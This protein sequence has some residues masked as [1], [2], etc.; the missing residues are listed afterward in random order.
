MMVVAA[1]LVGLR[2]RRRRK[3]RHIAKDNAAHYYSTPEPDYDTVDGE[4]RKL[5]V[6]LLLVDYYEN[7]GQGGG[8]GEGRKKES[9]AIDYY[10]D[11]ESDGGG[12]V[13]ANPGAAYKELQQSGLQE[14][15]YTHIYSTCEGEG[16]L[17]TRE[18]PAGEASKTDKQLAYGRPGGEPHY[19]ALNMDTVIKSEYDKPHKK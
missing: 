19:T 4:G 14:A 15:P 11:M 18:L 9:A 17:D 7:M 8:G 3:K 12:E 1:I 5:V 16:S 10:E 6:D 2:M 13:V